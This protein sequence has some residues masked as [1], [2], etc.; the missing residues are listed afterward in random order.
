MAEG[1]LSGI[2]TTDSK[3]FLD[4]GQG[5]TFTGNLSKHKSEIKGLLNI[6]DCKSETLTLTKTD[7]WTSQRQSR[8]DQENH[9]LLKWSYQAPPVSSDGCKV[10]G[11]YTIFLKTF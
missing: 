1:T 2:N 7:R 4:V 11:Y 6:P 9:V 8:I 5:T 10:G 3:I